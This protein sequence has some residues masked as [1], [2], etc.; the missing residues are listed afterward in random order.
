[1][2]HWSKATLN[3]GTRLL[4]CLVLL[5]ISACSRD[6]AQ[7][8]DEPLRVASGPSF[9]GEIQPIFDANCVS[10]HQTQGASGNLNL[11]SGVSFG[12]IVSVKSD[13]SPLL[14]VTPGKPDQSY[15]IRK[16]EGSHVAAG[17]SG[18]RMPLTGSL[19]AQSIAKLRDWVT[20]GAKAD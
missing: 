10:C 17:G 20:A 6:D 13:E 7:K 9:A 8:A 1:M 18:E 14:Y 5:L 16:V 2:T 15:L 3:R 19:D 4:P 12:A 11:E